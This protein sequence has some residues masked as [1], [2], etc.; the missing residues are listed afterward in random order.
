[1]Q[2]LEQD[3]PAANVTQ[4]K[5]R[6]V[7]G[8]GQEKKKRSPVKSKSA[9]VLEKESNSTP[10][11]SSEDDTNKMYK[12][13]VDGIISNIDG[14]TSIDPH[15][16]ANAEAILEAQQQL[17]QIQAAS[18]ASRTSLQN[19]L[20]ELRQR[21]RDEDSARLDVKNRMKTLDEH[22]RQA[23][24]SKREAERLLKLAKGAQK[25]SQDRLASKDREIQHLYDR[26][27]NLNAKV[28]T[29]AKRKK[30][31]IH[32]LE[33]EIVKE[34]REE[35]QAAEELHQ[36]KTKLDRLQQLLLEEE[37]NLQAAR[38]MAAERLV[39]EE[40]SHQVREEGNAGV[41][42][43]NPLTS[44]QPFVAP[45]MTHYDGSFDDSVGSDPLSSAWHTSSE[46]TTYS[47]PHAR[48]P[49]PL[50]GLG[51][52][53]GGSGDAFAATL[54][55]R[56]SLTKM[57]FSPF[58]FD[59]SNGT[60]WM[61]AN[62][63]TRQNSTTP[64]SSDLLPSNLFQN[65]DEDEPHDG[66]LPGSRSEQVEAALNLFGLNTSDTESGYDEDRVEGNGV[67][68]D[69]TA[70]EESHT[71]AK[72]SR[73]WWGGKQRSRPSD[74]PSDMNSE[75]SQESTTDDN[76]SMERLGKRRSLSIFPRMSLN[77]GAKSFL[78]SQKR[79]QDSR[80]GRASL[81]ALG[82][83]SDEGSVMKNAWS[84]SVGHL[85]ATVNDYESVKRAFEGDHPP[86]TK[87]YD[88]D[89]NQLE[90]RGWPTVPRGSHSQLSVPRHP[91]LRSVSDTQ[92]QMQSAKSRG[93]TSEWLDDMIMPLD[94]TSSRGSSTGSAVGI[95]T[96][97]SKPSRFALF[98]H[99]ADSGSHDTD[100]VQT[101][102]N[103]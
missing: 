12:S 92:A 77:P 86:D 45:N 32:F 101:N 1:M 70:Q 80:S 81:D 27:T 47:A 5:S 33:E 41:T 59:G 67:E 52:D 16:F 7:S 38:E 96:R 10:R 11:S 36:A 39:H 34:K 28:E 84:S 13:T 17:E 2:I 56:Q 55:R 61:P 8:K 49:I 72:R 69:Q 97:S 89:W 22:K 29:N 54:P 42:F 18:E 75:V 44:Q 26:L 66:I 21:K 102:T 87:G 35:V 53:L 79:A 85:P 83:A 71:P 90:G 14:P 94:R 31:Q 68:E 60:N 25:M 82:T 3:S 103:V 23:E 95:T 100:A 48:V 58:S 15:N 9:P 73:T 37:G 57:R 43:F 64:I 4:E 40:H 30:E 78:G 76:G 93:S 51:T 88:A 46:D 24:A 19:Q 74:I 65:A 63:L 50:A 20:D 91:T 62:S 98:S 99:S 6:G